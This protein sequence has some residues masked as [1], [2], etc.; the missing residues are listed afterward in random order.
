MTYGEDPQ[1]EFAYGVG[2]YDK[3]NPKQVDIGRMEATKVQRNWGW[4]RVLQDNGTR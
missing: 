4:Y 1:V 3:K 2:G